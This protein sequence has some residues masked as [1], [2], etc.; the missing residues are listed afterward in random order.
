MLSAGDI[1]GNI[2]TG[3]AL[4]PEDVEWVLQLS[5]R[6]ITDPGIGYDP[7]TG[8]GL[9]D[10]GQALTDLTMCSHYH[11]GNS[12]L[13]PS[14]Q[15]DLTEQDIAVQFNEPFTAP[16]GYVFEKNTDYKADVYKITGTFAHGLSEVVEA[17][18]VRPSSCNTFD[19]YTSS[20]GVNYIEPHEM[21][22]L[23]TVSSASAELYGYTYRIKDSGGNFLGYAPFDPA[24]PAN[25][26][27]AYTLR[28]CGIV[29]TS[30]SASV[31]NFGV[32]VYPNPA[33]DRHRIAVSD[34]E[35][36]IIQITLFNLN[37][38]RLYQ[39]NPKGEISIGSSIEVRINHLLPGIYFYR[40]V[41]KR[42][43]QFVN[44]IKI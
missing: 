14:W 28:T 35:N 24:T 31:N 41:S 42:G 15:T 18:W 39:L 8:F 3:A 7:E 29:S 1:P 22:V 10:A 12:N 36:E 44:F 32:S 5:A 27:M 9:L 33:S 17:G 25:V 13:T 34:P 40:I 26:R 38:S 37:G 6:D 21:A 43:V 4:A 2:G 20:G 30:E 11:F 23:S 19:Y 16:G